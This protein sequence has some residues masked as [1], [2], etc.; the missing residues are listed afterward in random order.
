MGTGWGDG[1]G[2]ERGARPS[3]AKGNPDGRAAAGRLG[4]E[5]VTGGRY[6]ARL[7]R[8]PQQGLCSA[9]SQHLA[10]CMKGE[11]CHHGTGHQFSESISFLTDEGQRET[12][13]LLE[14]KVSFQL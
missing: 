12:N 14:L 9:L 13:L 11:R 5:A 7:H 1:G 6:P 4:L 3:A 10:V 2:A 8:M